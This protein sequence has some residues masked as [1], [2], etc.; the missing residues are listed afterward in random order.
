MSERPEQK[1]GPSFEVL[2]KIVKR[3]MGAAFAA[4]LVPIPLVDMAIVTGVQLNLVAKLAEIYGIPFSQNR[5]R[6]IIAAL[7]GGTLPAYAA[8]SFAGLVKLIPVAGTVLGMVS[9]PTLSAASAYAVGHIFIEHFESGGTLLTFDAKK[10]A[11]LFKDLFRKGKQKATRMEWEG[12]FPAADQR[13]PDSWGETS[14]DIEVEV[15]VDSTDDD[16]TE[17]PPE[18]KPARKKK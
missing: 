16:K 10:G 13:G 18:D 14:E 8:P 3:H 6:S 2:D 12:S 4:G 9:M 11:A 7:V 5:A 15:D 1:D 17:P